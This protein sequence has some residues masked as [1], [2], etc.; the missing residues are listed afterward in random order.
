MAEFFES[1]LEVIVTRAI[2]R[3][4]E[5]VAETMRSLIPVDTGELADSVVV[6]HVGPWEYMIRPTAVS[7][8]GFPYGIVVDQGRGPVVPVN[9]KA[10][11]YKDGTFSKY[12]K[13]YSGSHFIRKTVSRYK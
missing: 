6:E 12:S 5:N 10:L 2:S 8:T 13:A 4:A 3:T 1:E 7:E 9:A 11:R